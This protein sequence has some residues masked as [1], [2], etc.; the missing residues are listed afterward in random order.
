MFPAQLWGAGCSRP[1]FLQP[2]RGLLRCGI[3]DPTLRL[4]GSARRPVR[5]TDWARARARD[6]PVV[7]GVGL[8]PFRGCLVVRAGPRRARTQLTLGG[9]DVRRGAAAG[10]P[11]SW[12]QGAP[13]ALPSP[14]GSLR[15]LC[16]FLCWRVCVCAPLVADAGGAPRSE[17]NRCQGPAHWEPCGAAWHMLHLAQ[18]LFLLRAV[19][20]PRQSLGRLLYRRPEPPGNLAHPAALSRPLSPDPI[21]ASAV[22][23]RDGPLSSLNRRPALLLRL[24]HFV[25]A[26]RTLAVGLPLPPPAS[27][28]HYSSSSTAL[29]SLST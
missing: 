22:R 26:T 19:F 11:D 14:F 18:T 16:L 13:P 10:P 28:T 8:L 2:F 6:G 5:G 7:K 1:S 25:S 20:W 23:L 21:E 15:L 27:R 29:S 24:A 4:S 12:R 3:P 17:D 9:S